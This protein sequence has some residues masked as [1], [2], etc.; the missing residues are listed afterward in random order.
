VAVTRIILIAV[1]LAALARP[2]AAQAPATEAAEIQT[3]E[4]GTWYVAAKA[5]DTAG[6]YSGWSNE[7]TLSCSGTL[8]CTFRLMWDAN[9]E[10]N[11][12]GYVLEWGR[13]RRVYTQSKVIPKVLTGGLPPS[14]PTNMRRR[15]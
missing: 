5:F 9:T 4:T 10:T 7:V 1:A 3:T 14:P 15:P 2:A 11:L 8:P 12:A 13:V 6:M